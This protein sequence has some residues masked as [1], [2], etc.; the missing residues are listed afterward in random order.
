MPYDIDL[1]AAQSL[2]NTIDSMFDVA[3]IDDLLLYVGQRIGVAAEE[4]V[5]AYPAPSGNALPL[6]YT[7]QRK[8]GSTFKSKFK[9]L[10]QQRKVMSLVKQ[11]KVPYRRTGTLGKSLTS[12]VNIAAYG[13]ADVRIGSNLD[14]AP[15]VIDKERQSHYHMG[16]WNTIQDDIEGALGELSAVGVR[17]V[18]TWVNR[19]L[20]RG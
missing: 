9:S 1:S 10:A 20:D 11:G 13:V 18:V 15:Y 12:A 7:R 16:T 3:E 17:A 14:Y 5:S 6:Y 2:L 19:R 4:K 8:D